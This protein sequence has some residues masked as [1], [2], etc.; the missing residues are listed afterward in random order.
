MSP[1][2]NNNNNGEFLY[3]AHTIICA[4]NTY[5]P[6]SLDPLIHAPFQLPFLEHTALAAIPALGINRTQV[7]HVRVKCPA[8][9]NV[10]EIMSQY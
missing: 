2:L 6:W 3:S 8:Q 10:I 1:S 4:I 7:K 9:R 5:H